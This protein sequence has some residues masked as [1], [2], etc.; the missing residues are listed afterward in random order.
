MPSIEHNM[1]ANKNKD[2]EASVTK[3][4][5]VMSPEDEELL[6]KEMDDF[7]QQ[8]EV[9]KKLKED[10]LIKPE[11]DKK[12]ALEKLLLFKKPYFKEVE[13]DGVVFKLKLLNSNEH[14]E[15]YQELLGLEDSNSQMSRT[16]LMLLAA[17]LTEVNG[18]KL[19]DAYS[20]PPEV[21]S[22]LKKKYYEISQWHSPLVSSLTNAYSL[23]VKEA[24]QKY[25]PNFLGK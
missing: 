20:G 1:I 2:V 21:K 6:R 4:Y 17:V 24:N 14:N 3:E 7:G 11:F 22:S 10:P 9:A 19:E 18:I 16:N 13:I 23:F 12:Q 15:V 5:V 8:N 25:N